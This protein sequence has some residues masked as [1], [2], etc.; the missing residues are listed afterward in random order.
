M[1]IKLI[2]ECIHST[3][4]N[5]GLSLLMCQTMSI[6]NAGKGL[7]FHYMRKPGIHYSGLKIYEFALPTNGFLA[8]LNVQ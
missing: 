1:Q 5:L 6:H 4:I 8:K 2:N 3:H 7:R